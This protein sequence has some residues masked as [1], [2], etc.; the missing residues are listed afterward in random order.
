MVSF[1]YAIEASSDD[2]VSRFLT[3]LG[4]WMEATTL[5]P[6][7]TSLSNG[8]FSRL[9]MR[10]HLY[11]RPPSPLSSSIALEGRLRQSSCSNC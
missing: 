11:N 9:L 4:A 7:T 8:Y 3:T 6:A 10:E 2:D 1:F 5:L